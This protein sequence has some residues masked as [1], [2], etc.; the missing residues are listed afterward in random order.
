MRNVLAKHQA[1]RRTDK[2]LLTAPIS[3]LSNHEIGQIHLAQARE[4]RRSRQS[5]ILRT[6]SSLGVTSLFVL[7]VINQN[8]DPVLTSNDSSKLQHC[9]EGWVG[10]GP[11]NPDKVSRALVAAQALIEGEIDTMGTSID[12]MTD[13]QLHH[14]SAILDADLHFYSRASDG[15]IE[16]TFAEPSGGSCELPDGS[17]TLNAK[18]RNALAAIN[19]FTDVVV[20][21]QVG[22]ARHMQ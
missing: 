18:A 2:Y 13:D 11:V 12:E 3:E 20:D 9:P 21:F 16:E 1:T 15:R 14:Y 17:S 22:T 6:I 5:T 8:D 10:T 7:G 4:R 19:R